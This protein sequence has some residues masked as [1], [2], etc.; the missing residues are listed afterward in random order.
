MLIKCE[1]SNLYFD[2]YTN[3]AFPQLDKKILNGRSYNIPINSELYL[4]LLYGNW[5]IPSS[6][7][8]D[9]AYHRG[10]GLVKSAYSKYWDKDLALW[11]AWIRHYM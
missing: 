3:P 9:T 11:H 4:T 6:N 7:H 8:A 1:S 2:I 10:P 5:K